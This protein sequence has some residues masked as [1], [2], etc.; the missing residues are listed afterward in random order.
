[1]HEWIIR[2]SLIFS[3]NSQN[4]SKHIGLNHSKLFLRDLLNQGQKKKTTM[5]IYFYPF[6]V[7]MSWIMA[8]TN[9]EKK[10]F[11]V[12]AIFCFFDF[13]KL[14]RERKQCKANCFYFY[15]FF[16]SRIMSFFFKKSIS[17]MLFIYLF[18]ELNYDFNKLKK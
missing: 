4:Q 12:H 7:F 13:H 15:L 8:A 9:W 16:M 6:V 11:S 17:V 10:K 18:Y 1:M 5:L 3:I 2:L 14:E